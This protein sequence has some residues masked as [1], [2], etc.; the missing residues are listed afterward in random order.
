MTALQQTEAGGP[1]TGHDYDGIRELDNPLPR[2]WLFTLYGAVVFSVVY[3]LYFHTLRVGLLPM[4]AYQDEVRRAQEAEDAREAALEA[5]G[6]GISDEQLAALSKD[7]AVLERGAAVYKQNCVACHGDRGQGIVGPNLTDA[8]WL[9]GGKARDIYGIISN[10][11]LE[12]GMPSWKP[13]LGATRVRE[14]AAFVLS[15]RDTRVAGKAPQG[16][17]LAGEVAP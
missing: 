13:V 14:T 10:G 11:V 7:P 16:T 5:Q 12:K 15:L 17:T 9:H 2:W 1:D 6:K 8:Y 3:W 4:A